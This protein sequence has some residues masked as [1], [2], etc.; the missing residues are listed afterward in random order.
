M[1]H[2]NQF[3]SHQKQPQ[4]EEKNKTQEQYQPI[5]ESLNDS[6]L[7]RGWIADSFKNSAASS[8][9]KSIIDQNTA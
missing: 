8:K 7:D 3:P 5:K 4:K 1:K 9:R 6:K 2:K